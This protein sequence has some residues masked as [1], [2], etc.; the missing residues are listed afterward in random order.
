[1]GWLAPFKGASIGFKDL[2]HMRAPRAL[3]HAVERRWARTVAHILRFE[4]DIEGMEHIDPTHSYVVV[5]LHKGLVD[6]IALM[7]L[8]L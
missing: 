3:V 5:A 6:A 4:L 7:H 2:G 8:P 1:M